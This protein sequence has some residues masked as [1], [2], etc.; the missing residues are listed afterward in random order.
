MCHRNM[1]TVNTKVKEKPSFTDHKSESKI[2]YEFLQENHKPEEHSI[3]NE[4]ESETNNKQKQLTN[5]YE[6]KDSIRDE[7]P[8]SYT[9]GTIQKNEE[10]ENEQKVVQE[11]P[12]KNYIYPS[13]RL[14]NHLC[15]MC[16]KFIR[17]IR[18][19]LRTHSDNKEFECKLCTLKYKQIGNLRAHMKIHNNIR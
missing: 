14:A 6:T 11:R 3:I 16:G 4:N 9:E 5:E 18:L 12:K 1:N 2:Y 7:S 13:K 19:H 15:Q 10:S 17:D 8:V